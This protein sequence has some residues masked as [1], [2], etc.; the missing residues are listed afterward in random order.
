MSRGEDD[1]ALLY[2]SQVCTEYIIKAEVEATV[3]SHCLPRL[4]RISKVPDRIVVLIVEM[5]QLENEWGVELPSASLTPC[6]NTTLDVAIE[7]YY[8]D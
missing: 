7:C 1:H 4:V 6:I 3:S 5:T 2:T 8:I